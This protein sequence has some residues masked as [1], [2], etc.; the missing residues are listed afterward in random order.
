[1]VLILYEGWGRTSL[2]TQERSVEFHEEVTAVVTVIVEHTDILRVQ[3]AECLLLNLLVRYWPL[4]FQV[5]KLKMYVSLFI[6]TFNSIEQ[7][8]SWEANRSS[9]NLEIPRILWIPEV[10]YRV[11]KRPPPVP[12]LMQ[13]NPV[14][15]SP[16]HFLSIHFNI[17]LPSSPGSSKLSLS[18]MSPHQNPVCTSLGSHTCHMPR[19]SHSSWFNHTNYIWCGVQIIVKTLLVEN[20]CWQCSG[21]ALVCGKYG[22][23]EVKWRYTRWDV[24]Y[25]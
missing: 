3:N 24:Q 4:G 7:S 21:E 14:H 19:R 17:I 25:P 16:F 22:L 18:L 6:K 11:H 5:L 23:D 12:I 9:S 13:I 10:H 1:M 2:R 15:A 8:P 20:P